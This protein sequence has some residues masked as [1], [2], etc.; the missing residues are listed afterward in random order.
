MGH[1][2]PPTLSRHSKFCP[3]L[4]AGLSRSNLWTSCSLSVGQR[5]RSAAESILLSKRRNVDLGGKKIR[6]RGSP[7]ANPHLPGERGRRRFRLPF[8]SALTVARYSAGAEICMCEIGKTGNHRSKTPGG[9]P[10]AK[11]RAR[12][13]RPPPAARDVT[14]TPLGS[15]ALSRAPE[16]TGGGGFLRAPRLRTR[17][18]VPARPRRL[19][20]RARAG[21]RGS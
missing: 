12:R 1:R 21:R 11:D 16:D 7:Y 6:L 14:G 9:P 4:R 20:E 8:Q 5:P 2:I 18:A 13:T 15:P 10:A 3:G 19:P 17:R